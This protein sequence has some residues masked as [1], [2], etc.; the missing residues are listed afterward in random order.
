MTRKAR[1]SPRPPRM[2]RAKK[3]IFIAKSGFSAQAR[4]KRSAISASGAARSAP[5]VENRS[6]QS[7]MVVA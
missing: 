2:S 3:A 7:L 4:V 1:R 6:R 5:T